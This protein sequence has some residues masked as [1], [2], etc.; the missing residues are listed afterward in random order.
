MDYKAID[1]K[2]KIMDSFENKEYTQKNE[3]F[4]H[5][6]RMGRRTYFFDLKVSK[7]EEPYLT[8]TESK[9]QLDQNTGDFYYEKQKIFL[10]KRDLPL[11]HAELGKVIKAIGN[12]TELSNLN[13]EK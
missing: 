12:C 3:V 13:E 4:S 2:K 8:I 9:R 11:F 6:V 1:N 10:L 7:S 5:A